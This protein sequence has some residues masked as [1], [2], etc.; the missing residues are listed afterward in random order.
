MQAIKIASELCTDQEQ[1]FAIVFWGWL[2]SHMSDYDGQKAELF[3]IEEVGKL[4]CGKQHGNHVKSDSTNASTVPVSLKTQGSY[5]SQ[6]SSSVQFTTW[7]EVNF[8]ERKATCATD[9][10]A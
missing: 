1:S 10:I 9:Q 2:R 7:L 3:A 4:L 5:S 6:E 8:R